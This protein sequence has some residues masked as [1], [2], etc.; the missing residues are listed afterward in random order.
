MCLLGSTSSAPSISTLTTAAPIDSTRVFA[1]A[2]SPFDMDAEL[3]KIATT[4]L[5]NR[6][7]EL[8]SGDILRYRLARTVNVNLVLEAQEVIGLA[9]LRDVLGFAPLGPWTNYREPSED[10]IAAVPT[11][12]AYYKLREPRSEMRSLDS[13]FFYE[14]SFPPAIAFL[15]KRIPAIRT[16]YRHKFEEIRRRPNANVTIDRKEVDRMIDEF[17]TISLRIYNAFSVWKPCKHLANQ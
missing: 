14:K 1:P 2:S 17:I 8:L 11:I 9:E 4:C 5:T 16:I 3:E 6:E 7:H 10:E 12:E 13:Q 15:D